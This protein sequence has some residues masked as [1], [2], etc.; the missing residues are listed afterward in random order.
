MLFK[1][2]AEI[3]RAKKPKKLAFCKAPALKITSE[4]DKQPDKSKIYYQLA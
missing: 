4:L 3:S 2:S 1:F